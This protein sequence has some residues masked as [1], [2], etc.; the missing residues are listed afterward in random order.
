MTFIQHR[1]N[2]HATSSRDAALTLMRHC[3]NIACPLG[4]NPNMAPCSVSSDLCLQCLF[5]LVFP[6]IK[7]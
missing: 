6:N 1:I 3:L 5:K 2:V 7:Y 4:I